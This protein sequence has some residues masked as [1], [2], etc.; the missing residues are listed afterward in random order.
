M[1]ENRLSLPSRLPDSGFTLIE[2]IVFI[3]VVSIA[4]L[5]VV[6]LYFQVATGAK[7]AREMMQAQYLAQERLEEMISEKYMGGGFASITS[8]NYPSQTNIDIGANINFD[9]TV[10][11]EGGSLA[12]GTMTCNGTGVYT[13]ESYK[14]VYVN[15]FR[16]GSTA[17]RLGSAWT[18]FAN[19]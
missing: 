11:I 10:I 12:G 17:N 14:C 3:V 7:F 9:R 6:P 5:A 4:L 8:A 18:T 16:N 2:L 15:V 13:A 1:P 19:Y